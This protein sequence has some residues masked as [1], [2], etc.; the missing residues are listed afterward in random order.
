MM[1]EIQRKIDIFYDY[2]IFIIS[3][4]IISNT[5]TLQHFRFSRSLRGNLFFFKS[6]IDDRDRSYS[7]K[8]RILVCTLNRNEFGIF[9]YT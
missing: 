9:F 7:H 5:S 8:V 2:T 1:I 6:S 3:G 4:E